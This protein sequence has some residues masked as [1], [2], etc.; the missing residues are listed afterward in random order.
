[1][2]ESLVLHIYKVG[3][4][5]LQYHLTVSLKD[6][7]A[8]T[9]QVSGDI[10]SVVRLVPSYAALTTV[11]LHYKGQISA[12][13]PRVPWEAY[14]VIVSLGVVCTTTSEGMDLHLM[15]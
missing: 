10:T 11:Y 6:M 4:L 5:P 8:S 14:R 2:A 9:P 3:C 7:S 13:L 15:A 1:M 12:V